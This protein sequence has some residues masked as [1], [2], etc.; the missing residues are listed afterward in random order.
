MPHHGVGPVPS[1]IMLVGEAWGAEEE[2]AGEPFVGASGQELN[3]MLHEAGIMRTEC[4]VTNL[5]NRRPP[6]NDLIKQFKHTPI[7]WI[8]TKKANITSEHVDLKNLKV[9]PQVKEGYDQLMAEIA[10]VQPNVIVACG[11]WAMWALTGKIGIKN[12]RGSLLRLDRELPAEKIPVWEG[13]SGQNPPKVIPTFHPAAVLRQWDWRADVVQD[14][15]RVKSHMH[16]RQYNFPERK[17]IIRPSFDQVMLALHNLEQMVSHGPTWLDLDLETRRGHTA[18]CGIS[19]SRTEAVIIPLMCVESP[20]GYWS[21]EEEAFIIHALYRILTHRNA[22]VRLQNGLYDAQYTWRHWHFIPRVAQDTMISQH[23]IFSDKPKALYYQ[24]SHYCEHYIY[25]KDEGKNWDPKLGEDQLWQYNGLDCV[26]TREC[27][28]VEIQIV[29]KLGLGKVHAFQQAMF[30]PVLKAMLRGVR[31]REKEAGRIAMEIDEQIS[32][33]KKFLFDVIGYEINIDSPKQMIDFFYQQMGQPEIMSRAKKGQPAHVTCD[34]EALTKIGRREPLLQPL[35]TCIADIRTL[36]QLMGFVMAKRDVDGRMR[37]SYN[38]GGSE[39]G[40]SAPKTYRLSSS[41][42]AFDSGDNLQNIPS[43]KSKSVGKWDARAKEGSLLASM[44]GQVYKL[45]NIR[46]MYGP[47]PGFTFFDLDLDRA[48][49][50]VVV[51]ECDDAML[52]AALHQGVDI[53]LLNAYIIS[54]K[55][56]PPLDELVELHPKY[57]DHRTPMKLIREFAKV[58]CHGTNYGGGARTMAANTGRTVHEIERAQKIWFGAH[59]GIK[60]WHDDIKAQV[61]GRRYVENKFGYRWYIFDR[62]DSIIPEAIAWVPQSTVSIV[63]NRIWMNLFQGVTEDKWNFDLEHLYKLL[64]S[65][66]SGIEVLLQV[67]DSLGGQFPTHM[68][69]ASIAKIKEL[70]SITIPYDDP[71]IIPTGIGTSEVTWGE[72]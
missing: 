27:G 12:W 29:E 43:E 55:E 58:F 49:L 8:A 10:S 26:N 23:A 60:R 41:K 46:A 13:A 15:R 19:W 63:I 28:E 18:C 62:L 20:E 72:C 24:A 31:I 59:P 61:F 25:W 36:D 5:V 11:N 68:K 70:S 4:F 38:I 16:S 34:D 2:Q 66:P 37:C 32:I 65:S 51:W 17:F 56:P 33:R 42:N 64:F 35:T 71:L 14:L 69:D 47:D 39:S 1:R 9:L 54:G 57:L 52:K 22:R 21:A 3:R 7:A 53:H 45:P 44:I 67:H 50:Q 48:D 40:K 30:Y 6:N